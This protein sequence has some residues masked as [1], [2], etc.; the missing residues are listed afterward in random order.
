[1]RDEQVFGGE[2]DE[3]GDECGCGLGLML[4]GIERHLDSI[5]N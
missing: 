4:D 2:H 1:M 3:C 5:P